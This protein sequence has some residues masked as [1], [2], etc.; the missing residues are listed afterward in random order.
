MSSATLKRNFGKGSE[1]LFYIDT[2]VWFDIPRSIIFKDI[3][4]VPKVGVHIPY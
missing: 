1:F 2:Y 3:N 4:G